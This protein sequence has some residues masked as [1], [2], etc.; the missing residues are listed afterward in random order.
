MLATVLQGDR[1]VQASIAIVRV[2]VRLRCMLDAHANL[3]RRLDELE[4][5][6]F[7]IVFEA[8][9]DLMALEP[10]PQNR[11]TRLIPQ[12]LLSLHRSAVLR[13]AG[14]FDSDNL[15]PS[16]FRL[17]AK[18]SG[19][20]RVSNALAMASRAN[21]NPNVHTMAAPVGRSSWTE[22]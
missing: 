17:A 22:R 9:R 1:A 19:S 16:S 20:L 2:F 12:E 21:T 3:A 5:K 15:P 11:I 10:V 6:C 7:R 4:K 14:Q 13:I 18:G 8:I